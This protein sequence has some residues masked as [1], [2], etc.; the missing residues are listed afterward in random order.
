MSEVLADRS[1][2]AGAAAKP[3]FSNTISD[4]IESARARRKLWIAALLLGLV[5]ALAWPAQRVFRLPSVAYDAAPSSPPTRPAPSAALIDQTRTV[6]RRLDATLEPCDQAVAKVDSAPPAPGQAPA[7][8]RRAL[9]ARDACRRAGLSLLAMRP[10]QA[11]GGSERAAF[12]EALAR[13]QYL[14]VVE[15]NS[16]ARLA[17]A[18]RT[19]AEGAAKFEAW[20]NVKDTNIDAL[21]CRTG[22]ISAARQA[23]LPPS[24]FE[25]AAPIKPVPATRST[26]RSRA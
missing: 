25:A 6:W 19:G 17:E 10:P 21:G 16:Y 5:A 14:Y 4:T 11:A 22:F 23:G 12:N 8:A 24:F 9:T 7:A 20:A 2:E 3:S 15:G 1:P 26:R 13:C 18:L